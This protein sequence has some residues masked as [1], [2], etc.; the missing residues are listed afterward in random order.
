[1]NY[2]TLRNLVKSH[3]KFEGCINVS[4][5]PLMHDGFPGTF[6]LSFTEY[7]WL[8]E[9]G[10]FVDF[11]HD[12]SFSTIQS[13]IRPDDFANIF[14]IMDS[15]KYLGPFEIADLT[16]AINLSEK[17]DYKKLQTWQINNLISF[18]KEVGIYPERIHPSYCAGGTVQEL[19]DGRYNFNFFVPEDKISK[20]AFLENGVPERNLIP[21]KTRDTFLSLH[22][23]RPTFWGYRT[24]VNSTRSYSD[25]ELV[26]IATTE[27]LPWRPVYLGNENSMKNI[28]GLEESK[29]GSAISALG[30]ERLCMVINEFPTVRDVDYISP[31]YDVFEEYIDKYSFEFEVEGLRALHR[32]FSDVNKYKISPGRHQ[33]AKLKD[34]FRKSKLN[35]FTKKALR[36]VLTMHSQTQPWH[37]ELA[38]GIEPTIE[39]IERYKISRHQ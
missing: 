2:E 20:E 38:D 11:D 8:R 26:D 31:V 7:D 28:V 35:R 9:Y 13:C 18:L 16:G 15:W 30:L 22:L 12:F 17:P 32:V 5:A 21:D 24:E 37:P 19:T 39:R 27:Y 36:E 33:K 4:R 29:S 10:K 23:Q 34:L 25:P 14:G 3:P 1:M 6:N